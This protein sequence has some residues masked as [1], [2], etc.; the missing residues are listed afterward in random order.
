MQ[1]APPRLP[2]R[3][4]ASIQLE[5][6]TRWAK[7][8]KS[9]EKVAKFSRMKVRAS[10]QPKCVLSPGMGAARSHQASCSLP[11]RLALARK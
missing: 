9:G 7:S 11:R 8:R 2:V 5:S 6:N 1:K 10:S 3:C 4:S